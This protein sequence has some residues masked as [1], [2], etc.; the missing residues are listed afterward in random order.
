[1]GIFCTLL[2]GGLL[3]GFGGMVARRRWDCQPGQNRSPYGGEK[4]AQKFGWNFGMGYS[5]AEG[6]EDVMPRETID[7]STDILR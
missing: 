7:Q 2:P 1:M 4:I 3:G 5:I 6:E